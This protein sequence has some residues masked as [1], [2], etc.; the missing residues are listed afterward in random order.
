MRQDRHLKRSEISL[1][2]PCWLCDTDSKTHGSPQ[3]NHLT[4]GE[5]TWMRG[6]YNQGPAV[7]SKSVSSFTVLDVLISHYMDR[8]IY[9]HLSTVVLAGHSAGGQMVQRYAA[10][11]PSCPGNSRLHFWVANPGTL[12]WLTPDRPVK[13]PSCEEYD[14]Y[15][16]GLAGDFVGYAKADVERLGREG[17]VKRYR[18]RTVHYA[19]GLKDTGAGGDTR[20]PAKMQGA[21]RLERGRNFVEMLKGMDGGIPSTHTIDWVEG[22]GHDTAGMLEDKASLQRVS[23]RHIL[24]VF[25]DFDH[26][27]QLFGC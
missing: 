7:I 11:R 18:S 15:K 22:V 5:N 8:N 12:L 26:L 20:C 2:V 9:P 14:N 4:W 23:T 13:N 17:I 19:W 10:L 25:L 6:N 21:S 16:Y 1:M 27:P 3:A 24:H